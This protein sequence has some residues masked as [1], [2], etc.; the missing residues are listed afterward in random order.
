MVTG[1][2][3]LRPQKL[4]ARVLRPGAT[5]CVIA[6]ALASVALLALVALSGCR[7]PALLRP[8]PGPPL[9]TTYNGKTT[10]E[11]SARVGIY[12]FFDDPILNELLTVGLAQNLE[13][14]IRNQE[15]AIA[16]NEIM[17]RRGAYLPFVNLGARGGFERNS[18]FTPL[19]AAETQLLSPVGPFPDPLPNWAIFADLDWRIDIWRQLR[20]ARDSAI[21]RYVEAI[22]RRNFLVTQLVA[23]T[24]QNYYELAALQKRQEFLNQTIALQEQSLEVTRLQQ[25]AG[26]GSSL[27]VQRLL[28]EVR[29]NEAQRFIIRQRTI[30]V[31]NEINFLVGRFP[32]PVEGMKWDFITL[33]A[34]Q[35]YVGVPAQLLQ[36]RR[37]IQAA[38]REVIA[39]GLDVRVARANFFPTLDITASVGYEAFNPKYFFNPEA[40]AARAAGELVGPLINKAAIRAEYLTANARQLQAIYDYQRT[41]LN[42]FTEVTNAVA[43]AENYRQS[44]AIQQAQV[45]S[46][47]ESV[48]IARELFNAPLE[49]PAFKVDYIDILLAT[50][51]QLEARTALIETKQQQLSAIVRAYQ[52]L[53]GGYLLTSNGPEFCV[54]FTPITEISSYETINPLEMISPPDSNAPPMSDIELLPPPAKTPLER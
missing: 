18:R 17:A 10:E 2:F 21:N 37:D 16:S 20:N 12:E 27:A 14:K 41:V 4:P 22:E 26:R 34:R 30:E 39:S 54:L 29:K 32:Q 49:G 9:P 45:K 3:M 42:A 11:N 35:L 7:I 44:V 8:D 47:E 24:A 1:C 23:D 40:L 25:K 50:R 6:P 19:G 46:L 15:L 53:G 28:A 38:E 51:D 43:K 31:Q 36:N 13:L 52:A 5:H 48:N 33:D